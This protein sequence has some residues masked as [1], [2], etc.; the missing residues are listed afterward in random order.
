M[1]AGSFD[2]SKN[3]SS[4]YLDYWD[5]NDYDSGT[6]TTSAMISIRPEP[7]Y[8]RNKKRYDLQPFDWVFFFR[9]L[10]YEN[11]WVWVSDWYD[12]FVRILIVLMVCVF[13]A[14]F[15]RRILFSKSGFVGR[16]AKKRKGVL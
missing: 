15:Q 14:R 4:T 12:H 10:N 13:T 6:T 9:R 5:C 3:N 2:N 8:S 11:S 1:Y 16:V 7:H